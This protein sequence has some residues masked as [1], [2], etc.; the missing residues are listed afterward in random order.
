MYLLKRKHYE[1]HH[2]PNHIQTLFKTDT[3]TTS[4]LYK[5]LNQ[6][7]GGDMIQ[8]EQRELDFLAEVFQ[9][10]IESN[11]VKSQ[12]DKGRL[13]GIFSTIVYQNRKETL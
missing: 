4:R 13:L 11:M 8:L 9:K 5:R 6:N 1:L 2:K 10:Y 3:A 7:K 12:Q